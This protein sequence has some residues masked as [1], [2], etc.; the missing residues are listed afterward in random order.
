MLQSELFELLERTADAAFCVDE[1]GAICSWNAAAEKAFRLFTLRGDWQIV[2]STPTK[3][4]SSWRPGLHPVS[5]PPSKRRQTAGQSPI[6]TSK[7]PVH[8]GRRIRG[9]LSTLIFKD[10]RTHPGPIVQL[11]RDIT[12]RK[13]KEEL[14]HNMLQISKQIVALSDGNGINIRIP[15][16]HSRNRNRAY[17]P[18]LRWKQILTQIAKSPGITLQTL[19]NHLHHI[20]EK[21]ETLNCL[22]AVMHAMDP[23]LI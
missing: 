4:R 8:S 20:N 16:Q 5:F 21:L 14:L 23:R 19:R 18:V 12:E 7:S 13:Q 11:A 17:A 15:F 10:G 3:P 9:D 22:Q 1:Q 6:S 2:F